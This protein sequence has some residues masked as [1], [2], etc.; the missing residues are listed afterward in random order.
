VIFR[1]EAGVLQEPYEDVLFDVPS[2]FIG[3]VTD[4]LSD[5]RGQVRDLVVGPDGRARIDVRI[6]SQG[7][8]GFRSG[9]LVATRGQGILHAVFSGYD[10]AGDPVPGRVAGALVADRPGK[11][12]PYALWNLQERGVIFIAPGTGVY[13]GMIIGES[14]REQDIPC[15]P[16]RE[17]HLTNVRA[18]HADEE[19]RLS[20]TRTLTL[21]QALLWINSTEMVEVTPKT[22]RIRKR[23]LPP[24]RGR[25]A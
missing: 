20:R 8:L 9:F 13:P 12:T 5:R 24:A 18:A 4:E 23:V 3:A 7:L 16:T 15:N 1:E 17:K 2:G 10:V 22:F 11:A 21:D 25:S 19:I 6:P 14:S